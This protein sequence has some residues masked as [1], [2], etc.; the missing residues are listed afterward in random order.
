[1]TI[2]IATRSVSLAATVLL[3]ASACAQTSTASLDTSTSSE[4]PPPATEPLT[5]GT[6]DTEDDLRASMPGAGTGT[7]TGTETGTTT[8]LTTASETDIEIDIETATETD[9]ETDADG[10]E[11]FETA[12]SASLLEAPPGDDGPFDPILVAPTRV[13]LELQPT[14]SPTSGFDPVRL[15]E[16]DAD[17]GDDGLLIGDDLVFTAA[18]GCGDHCIDDAQIS[19][20]GGSS[21]FYDLMVNLESPATVDAYLSLAPIER[22]DDGAYV[23]PFSEPTVSKT[24]GFNFQ[25]SFNL[26]PATEYHLLVRAADEQGTSQVAGSFTTAEAMGPDQLA[27]PSPCADGCL[28]DVTFDADRDGTR[29]TVGFASTASAT[30]D[31]EWSTEQFGFDDTGRPTLTDSTSTSV[32][33]PADATAT[34]S[35]G[36]LAPDTA[37]SVIVTATDDLGGVDRW[38]ARVATPPP[39]VFASI[40]FLHIDGDGDNG[41]RNRGEIEF[42]YGTWGSHWGNRSESKIGSNSNVLLE[43]DA[44]GHIYPD[45][46]GNYDGVIIFAGERDGREAFA[47]FVGSSETEPQWG[48]GAMFTDCGTARTT[49]SAAFTPQMS[50]ADLQALPGCGDLAV[51]YLSDRCLTIETSPNGSDEVSFNAVVAYDIG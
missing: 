36:G 50:Y 23:R 49:W 37:Y 13:A 18:T 12:H 38:T 39:P 35:L 44:A 15:V 4:L 48:P 19:T 1:M 33:V 24:V 2:R 27:T 51:A 20:A 40:H 5:E 34:W 3:V 30:V 32:D 6:I 17:P 22:T 42:S 7:G 25:T 11:I 46:S 43:G 47:C 8:A 45:S 31:L 26:E 41:S 21:S 29:F 9:I 14:A 16:G 10:E 28:D